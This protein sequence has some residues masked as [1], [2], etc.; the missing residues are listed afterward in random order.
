MTPRELR[1]RIRDAVYL[2]SPE[3]AVRRLIRA[4][5]DRRALLETISDL[6]YGAMNEGDYAAYTSMLK[7]AENYTPRARTNG[8]RKTRTKTR[9]RARHNPI[10]RENFFGLFSS[11]PPAEQFDLAQYAEIAGQLRPQLGRKLDHYLIHAPG[12]YGKGR[13]WYWLMWTDLRNFQDA[14]SSTFPKR[15]IKSSSPWHA[16]RANLA[17]YRNGE[18]IP[19]GVIDTF[20]GTVEG[21]LTLADIQARQNP[22]SRRALARRNS[23]TQEMSLLASNMLGLIKALQRVKIAAQVAH[24]NARGPQGYSDHLLFERIYSKMDKLIDTMAEKYVSYTGRT[25]PAKTMAAVDPDGETLSV[26]E[27][28]AKA[29]GMSDYVRVAANEMHG[30][31]ILPTNPSGLDDY[32]MSLNNKL[33]T[34]YYLVTSVRGQQ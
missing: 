9:S 26:A 23:A 7:T 13:A 12:K 30:K 15:Y 6:Y 2:Q 19:F 14:K 17:M 21:P 33:D 34:F 29:R 28:I 4:G 8:R 3:D 20:A 32:L 18:S 25:I 24:W 22:G 31:G 11:G 5:V 27:E 1:K 10:A 16:V